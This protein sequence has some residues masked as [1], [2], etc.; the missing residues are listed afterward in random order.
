MYEIILTGS[1]AK[2]YKKVDSGTRQALNEC[3]D[4]LKANPESHSCIK[5][6]HGRL[7]GLYRYRVGQ[8]RIVYKIEKANNVVVILA[9]APRGSIYKGNIG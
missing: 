8:I 2:Y 5:K 7:K 3:F 9:I 4:N 6:L 1:A